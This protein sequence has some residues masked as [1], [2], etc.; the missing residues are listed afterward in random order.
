MALLSTPRP[1]RQ[2]SGLFEYEIPPPSPIL[3]CAF[4]DL[5]RATQFRVV[6]PIAAPLF[7]LF[8][9]LPLHSPSV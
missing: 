4:W 1:R 8:H 3:S 5:L 6:L 2:R 7:P 9:H